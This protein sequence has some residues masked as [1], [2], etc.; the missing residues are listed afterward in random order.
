VRDVRGG[1][2]SFAGQRGTSN[3][4]IVDGADNNNTFFRADDRPDGVRSPY[5]FSQDAVRE[6]RS[7]ATPT[8][9]NTGARAARSST[10]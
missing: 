3:S 1:D 9:R 2:L 6:F 8:W 5:Q 4:L 7:T 10:S